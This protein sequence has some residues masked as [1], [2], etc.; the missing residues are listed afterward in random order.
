M[1]LLT[2]FVLLFQLHADAFLMLKLFLESNI[3]HE[4]VSHISCLQSSV[5]SQLS[6][7][8]SKPWWRTI[9]I[10]ADSMSRCTLKAAEWNNAA[11]SFHCVSDVTAYTTVCL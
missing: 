7:S 5:S 4:V 11:P 1:K 10:N 6:P 8:C 9:E 2:V 3:D